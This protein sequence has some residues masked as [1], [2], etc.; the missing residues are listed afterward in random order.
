MNFSSFNWTA[1]SCIVALVSC[2]VALV[3]GIWNG[4]H[5]LNYE[6]QQHERDTR[7]KALDATLRLS[8][9]AY[10]YRYTQSDEVRTTASAEINGLAALLQAYG[11]S[12]DVDVFWRFE[13]TD[14]KA[15]KEIKR[16]TN[17]IIASP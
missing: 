14:D 4:K 10:R 15:R 5:T 7:A 16:L 8:M 1:A 12:V 17:E 2:I 11:Y 3:L 13:H 6:K 9:A